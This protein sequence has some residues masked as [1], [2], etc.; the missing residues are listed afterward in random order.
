MHEIILA[1]AVTQYFDPE[2]G[3]HCSDKMGDPFI[4]TEAEEDN[5]Q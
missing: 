3:N 2:G 1:A 4:M 5:T